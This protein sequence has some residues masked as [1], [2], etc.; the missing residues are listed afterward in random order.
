[1]VMNINTR[2]FQSEWVP[3]II[4]R[5]GVGRFPFNLIHWIP[6]FVRM[7]KSELLEAPEMLPHF[8]LFEMGGRLKFMAKK[9]SIVVPN[10]IYLKVF[11]KYS[12]NWNNGGCHDTNF[13]AIQSERRLS[14][15]I[16]IQSKE[17]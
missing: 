3:L 11:Q 5:T 8:L 7:K 2:L 6:F 17:N 12:D 15:K 13:K 9:H 1:M 10:K 4:Y 14:R 16:S